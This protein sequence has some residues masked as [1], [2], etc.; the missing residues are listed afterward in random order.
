MRSPTCRS[1]YRGATAIR[2]TRQAGLF[3]RHRSLL[4]A[5]GGHV[6]QEDAPEQ[7]A[8]AIREWWET[9]VAEP[10]KRTTPPKN[11]KGVMDS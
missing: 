10:G 6:P 1:C 7:I 2:P 11:E 5:G 9:N 8:K 3:P 4:I